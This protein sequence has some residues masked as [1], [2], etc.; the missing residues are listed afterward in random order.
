MIDPT[1]IAVLQ[2]SEITVESPAY[3]AIR[4]ARYTGLMALIGTATF[5]LTAVA[6]ARRRGADEQFLRAVC[7]RA[8]WLAQAGVVVLLTSTVLRLVAQ[9]ITIGGPEALQS[10]AIYRSVLLRTEWGH[11]WVIEFVAALV[12]MFALSRVRRGASWWGVAATAPVLAIAAA[13]S[14]HA[15]A[16]ET[17]MGVAVALDAIHVLAAA[18][19]VG[20]IATLLFAAIPPAVRMKSS[21]SL[22][23][24]VHAFSP[25]A[26]TCA[27]TL[28]ISGGPAAWF[29]LGAMDALLNTQYGQRLLT[30]LALLAVMA[31]L[32]AYNWR[33]VAPALG[34]ADGPARLR[35]SAGTELVFAVLIVLVTAVLVA[36][37]TP[38]E[39]H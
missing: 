32:G 17:R 37:P 3:V 5:A 14:G 12:T 31:A 29:Q 9:L 22:A 21:T 35:R 16:L 36:T 18:G 30:K 25:T 28:V 11:G 4:F 15:V 6:R 39:H 20:G 2:D 34:N 19:W 23:T 13:I 7:G 24:L 10:L 33:R 26:L 27:A 8:L 1:I 38:V